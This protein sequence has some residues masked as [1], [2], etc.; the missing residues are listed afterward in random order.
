M[1]CITRQ[2]PHDELLELIKDVKGEPTNYDWLVLLILSENYQ[3]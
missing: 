3:L 2:T 1:N